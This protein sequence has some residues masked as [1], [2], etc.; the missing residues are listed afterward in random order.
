[1]AQ[2]LKVHISL[3]HESPALLSLAF[4]K[5]KKEHNAIFRLHPQIV[6]KAASAGEVDHPT[7]V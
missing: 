5:R 3:D 2:S 6:H 1:M 4:L 7:P